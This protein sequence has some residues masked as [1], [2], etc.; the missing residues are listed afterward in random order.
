MKIYLDN[1]RPAPPGWT[2]VRTLADARRHLETTAVERISLDHDLDD[3][4]TGL[5]LLEWMKDTGH[6]PRFAPKVH[7]G[8][9]EGAIAMKKFVSAYC[10]RPPAPKPPRRSRPLSKGG[11]SRYGE[12]LNRRLYE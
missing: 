2:A 5:Q 1:R 4:E 9:I 12:A 8:N 11:S 3:G 7:S 6:W 10:G